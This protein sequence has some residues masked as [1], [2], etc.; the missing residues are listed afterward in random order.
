MTPTVPKGPYTVEPW[1]GKAKGFYVLDS[2]GKILCSISPRRLG[3]ADSIAQ[4]MAVAP[5]LL[6]LAR[7]YERWESHL[8]WDYDAWATEDGLPHL[9]QELYD[10]LMVLQ[11]KRNIVLATIEGRT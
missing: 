8:I 5:E 6:D 10:E 3:N 2:E 11:G 4:L 1:S 9:T 7:S